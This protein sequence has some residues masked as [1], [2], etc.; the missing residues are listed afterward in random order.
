MMS[1]PQHRRFSLRRCPAD[2]VVL[3]ALYSTFDL[4]CLLCQIRSLVPSTNKPSDTGNIQHLF[5]MLP[6]K[7]ALRPS[8][9]VIQTPSSELVRSQLIIIAKAVAEPSTSSYV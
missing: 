3:S 6:A 5:N 4:V 7:R 1:G 8:R 2:S 9:N